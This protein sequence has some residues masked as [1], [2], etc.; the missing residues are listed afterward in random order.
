MSDINLTDIKFKS[1]VKQM[2]APAL[3]EDPATGSSVDFNNGRGTVYL[4][5]SVATMTPGWSVKSSLEESDNQSDWTAIEESERVFTAGGLYFQSCA[6]N[7]RY[8]RAIIDDI[9]GTPTLS[10]LAF[11]ALE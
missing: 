9:T 10:I 6:R 11:Q 4:M 8:L 2:Y 1:L 7:K 3:F 5:T